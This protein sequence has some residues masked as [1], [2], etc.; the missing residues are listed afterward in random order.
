MLIVSTIE[1]IAHLFC[2][3]NNNEAMKKDDKKLMEESNNPFENNTSL[4]MSPHKLNLTD[5][6]TDAVSYE[7][8]TATT[9]GAFLAGSSLTLGQLSTAQNPSIPSNM[10]NV[11]QASTAGGFVK[12]VDEAKKIYEDDKK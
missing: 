12:G 1:V 9:K 4:G 7:I 10:I 11:A 3:M 6:N 5:V 8:A 2:N